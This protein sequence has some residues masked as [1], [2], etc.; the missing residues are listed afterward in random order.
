MVKFKKGQRVKVVSHI[1]TDSSYGMN[2]HM[3]K[4]IDT[5]QTVQYADKSTVQI[6]GYHWNPDDMEH[7]VVKD[8]DPQ[9]FHYDTSLL[10]IERNET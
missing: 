1:N 4:M 10:D 2:D 5:I 3:F 6:R 9:I 7:V 8:K